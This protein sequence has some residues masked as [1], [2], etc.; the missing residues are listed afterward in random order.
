MGLID[1]ARN[2]IKEKGEAAAKKLER[3]EFFGIERDMRENGY[4][5]S[6]VLSGN[7]E[8]LESEIKSATKQLDQHFSHKFSPEVTALAWLQMMDETITRVVNKYD[9]GSSPG[10]VEHT[11]HVR[12]MIHNDKYEREI[13]CFRSGIRIIE[14]F[15]LNDLEHDRDLDADDVEALA[16]FMDLPDFAINFAEAGEEEEQQMAE[17]VEED[18]DSF[19]SDKEAN[20][21]QALEDAEQ[22][23]QQAF[24]RFEE[25]AM[26]DVEK[27]IIT[28]ENAQEMVR[29]LEENGELSYDRFKSFYD[30]QQ[31]ASLASS[32]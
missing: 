14:D 2:A 30:V 16:L 22:L 12:K 13:N 6:A 15:G 9:K 11:N 23:R 29:E 25:L 17:Q 24:E 10:E 20:Y 32:Y 8:E 1:S 18:I 26:R 28:R 27:G 4:N 31:P 19:V 5:E 3:Q 21:R 7:I